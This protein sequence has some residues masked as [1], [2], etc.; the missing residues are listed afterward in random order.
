MLFIP[1]C[2]SS[3]E[4]DIKKQSV[5]TFAFCQYSD[6]RSVVRAMRQMDG[7][8]LGANRIKLGFGKSMPTR[9]VWIDGVPENFTEKQLYDQFSRFGVVIHTV[10]DREKGHALIFYETVST[11]IF[12]TFIQASQIISNGVISFNQCMIHLS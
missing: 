5:S 12:Y 11:S 3:Q 1:V 8:H 6:I 9:C 2:F 7:E 4:I 10:I